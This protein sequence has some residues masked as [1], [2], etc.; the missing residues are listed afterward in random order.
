MERQ[1]E[2]GY[3]DQ[4]PEESPEIEEVSSEEPAIEAES[5]E[6]EPEEEED[7]R[8]RGRPPANY[9][10]QQIQREKYQALDALNRM[11]EENEHLKRLATDLNYKAEESDSAA[12]LHYDNSINRKLEQA[13]AKKLQAIENGDIQSQLDADVEIA[14]A[15]SEL[16]QIKSWKVKQELREQQKQ[17]QE[18]YYQQYP[19]QQQVNPSFDESSA[20]KWL[21]ENPWFVPQ[22][23]HYNP[24]LVNAVSDYSEKVENYLYRAGRPD[25]IMSPEYFQEINNYVNHI[26]SSGRNQLSM[27][28]SRAG[29][30]PVRGGISQSQSREKHK[31]S[32]DEIDWARRLGISEEA[33][34][35]EKLSPINQSKQYRR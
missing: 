18:A 34:S 23:E 10:I 25:L 11:R 22:S 2:Y 3:T 9:R 14:E 4:E 29:V 27:K 15:T 35:K 16:Q 6:E 12:M 19:Q 26:Q 20:Y 1:E 33:Y 21:D 13:K 28:P 8:K 7:S 5:V 32:S 17:H 30:S 24:E 31:L